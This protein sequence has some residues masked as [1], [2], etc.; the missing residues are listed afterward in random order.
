[1]QDTPASCTFYFPYQN[2]VNTMTLH[3]PAHWREEAALAIAKSADEATPSINPHRL[4]T[5]AL[6]HARIIF[7][8]KIYS[9]KLAKA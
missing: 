3:L 5:L 4:S 9:A 6:I 2:Q 7:K 1:V 8:P